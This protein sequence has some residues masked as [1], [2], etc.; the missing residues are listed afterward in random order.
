MKIFPA[1]DLYGGAAVRLYKGDYNKTKPEFVAA[2][3]AR[4]YKPYLLPYN[5]LALNPGTDFKPLLPLHTANAFKDTI[6]QIYS[7]GPK[8]EQ[9]LL[10]CIVKAYRN[11]GIDPANPAT[12]N[13]RAPT[14]A[15][16]Y[17]ILAAEMEDRP[18]DKL[19]GA[20]SKLHQFCLFE[21]DPQRAVSLDKMLSGVVVID[22]SGYDSDIQSTVVAITLNQFYDRMISGG[23]SPTDGRYRQ[24]RRFIMVDEADTF[25]G[26]DFPS[27]RR[28]MKEGREFGV[29][30]ILSTQS[31]DHYNGNEDNYAR[32]VLSWVVHNVSD[33]KQKQVEFL[34][35]LRPKSPEVTRNYAAIKGLQKHHSV[36]KLG[37][38]NPL[39]IENKAFYQLYQQL[40]G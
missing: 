1:I 27:L 5:P 22:I 25:M 23:S 29:G 36:V 7:L 35:R 21:A 17:R 28:I 30:V 6:S 33:L 8:Q 19:M 3:D 14:V 18:A 2:T 20:M 10:D 12:W 15:Q 31:L 32:Y 26:Q 37:N 38:G 16:V 40:Q 34:F 11:Q 13:R 9:L 24:L 4:V 39:T